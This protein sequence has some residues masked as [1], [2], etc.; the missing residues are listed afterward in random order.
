MQTVDES[1]I[2]VIKKYIYNQLNKITDLNNISQLRFAAE[3]ITLL[4][5]CIV[6]ISKG[7]KLRTIIMSLLSNML[8]D[9]DVYALPNAIDFAPGDAQTFFGDDFMF[10]HN[11]F[12]DNE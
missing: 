2:F 10:Y 11:K 4:S 6:N 7:D 3:S 12:V 1:Q 5:N 8:K 9:F